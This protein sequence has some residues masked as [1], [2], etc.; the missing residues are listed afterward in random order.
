MRLVVLLQGAMTK[1][2]S[3]ASS[4][5]NAKPGT[6][7]IASTCAWPWGSR[8]TPSCMRQLWSATAEAKLPELTRVSYCSAVPL[9][10]NI[11]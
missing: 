4:V 1:T 6:R 8:T 10:H 7:R 11:F 3:S 2:S 9:S 5:P